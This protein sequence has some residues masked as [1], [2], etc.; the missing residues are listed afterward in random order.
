MPDHSLVIIST[1]YTKM[2]FYN[3]TAIVYEANA[4]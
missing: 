2:G 1:A 4:F 3:F